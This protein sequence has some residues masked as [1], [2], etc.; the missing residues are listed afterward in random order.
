M[1]PAIARPSIRGRRAGRPPAGC[2]RAASRHSPRSSDEP[3]ARG[4]G[5][6]S[7]RRSRLEAHPSLHPFAR[8]LRAVRERR[9][10]PAAERVLMRRWPRARRGRLVSAMADKPSSVLHGFGLA[11]SSS[12]ARSRIMRS[13]LGAC[14]API[15]A[16]IRAPFLIRVRLYLH[17]LSARRRSIELDEILQLGFGERL[18]V[19]HDELLLEVRPGEGLPEP[20]PR[21]SIDTA[22][23]S[24]S[25]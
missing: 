22:P 21:S 25:G 6:R 17:Q 3:R 2:G 23:T 15:S 8:R 11:R 18:G 16:P 10:S 5:S 14:S 12:A 1:A 24:D 4:P 19:D 20:I 7:R 13:S 9:A